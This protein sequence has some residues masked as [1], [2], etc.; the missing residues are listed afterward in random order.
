MRALKP[1]LVAILILALS[2]PS[3][4]AAN[5]SYLSVAMTTD[6]GTADVQ[7]TTDMYG[8]PLNIY[9]R[10]VEAVTVKPGESRIVPGLAEKWTVSADGLVYTFTLRKGVKFHNGET[11]KADDVL[12]TFDRMLDPKTKAL[13]T[14]FLDMIAG[15][16][17]RMSGKAATVSGL[18]VVNNLTIQITLTKPFAPFIANIATPAGSIYNR[19]ATLAAGDQFG[20][21]PKKTIGTGPFVLKEWIVNDSCTL[22]AFPGYWGG[23]PTLDGIEMLVI[24]DANTQRLMFETNKLDVLDLDNARSQVPYFLES[25][26]WKSQVVSGP[27]VGIYYYAINQ[28]IK[29]FGDVRVRK[30]MQLAIDRKLLL[31]KLFNGRGSLENGIFPKGLLGFNPALPAI[32]YDQKKAKDLLAQAGFPS[33]FDMEIAQITDSP[34][35]LKINEAVQAMLGE[36]GIRVKIVQMDSATYFATRKTGSLPLYESDWS[37]DFNDPDNFIYT[38]FSEKNSVARS[39]NYKNTA[40]Q[41]KLDEARVMVDQVKRMKLYQDLEKTIIQDDAGWIPLFSLEHLFVVQPKV[42]NFKVSWNG[43]SNM[44]YNGITITK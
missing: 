21:D 5:S 32:S 16:G 17:D 40:A 25:A 27:R 29:P 3:V 13:N 10:L 33:G 15:A 26:K 14:D 9:D 6:P 28:G 23:K 30:A 31:D 34:S 22:V 36:V 19:K 7:K 12:F 4:F 8:I 1:V 43:W 37:A 44:P 42:K 35:T 2:V 20:L 11:L 24:P 41:A 18:K 38:F 39:F